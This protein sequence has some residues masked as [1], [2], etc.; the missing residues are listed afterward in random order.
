VKPCHEKSTY[1]TAFIT[2]LCT[3]V[4][5]PTT[6]NFVIIIPHL[7]LFNPC[8]MIV[9]PLGFFQS[10]NDCPCPTITLWIKV[11]YFRSKISS[12]R[13]LSTPQLHET[14]QSSRCFYLKSQTY[15]Y[16]INGHHTQKS[17]QSQELAQTTILK[18]R[19]HNT[20][21]KIS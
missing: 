1:V 6:R 8:T 9:L 12:L 14:F 11:K 3:R 20:C 4:L 2:L 19:E 18:R 15:S 13:S 16:S 5:H 10:Q 7:C 17:H 21:L